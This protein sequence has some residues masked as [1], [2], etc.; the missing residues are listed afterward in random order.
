MFKNQSLHPAG[1]IY[2]N[3]PA[4]IVFDDKEVARTT[5]LWETKEHVWY[6]TYC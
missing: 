6:T 1:Y 4:Q 5:E 3:S 2:G